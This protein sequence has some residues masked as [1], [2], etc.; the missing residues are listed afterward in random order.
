MPLQDLTPQLRTRLSR[1]E[2]I[3]GVFIF[4]AT[5][6]MA[7][8]LGFYLYR[9]ALT[10]GW[11]LLKAPYYT[12]LRSGSGLRAGD[13][14]MMMGFP[15]G[16]ITRVEAMPPGMEQDVVVQFVVLGDKSGYIWSDS[17]VKVKS[18]GLLGNRY[19][20]VV[21]GDASGKSGK[22]Y[23]TYRTKGGSTITEMFD[24]ESKTYKPWSPGQ[25]IELRAEEPPDLS[26]HLD[27]MVQQAKDAMPHILALTN[28][29]TRVMANTADATEKLNRVLDEAGPVVSNLGEI[30]SN[31]K[32]PNGSLGQW[33]LPTNL[34]A[35]VEQAVTS[36]NTVLATANNTLTNAN[37]QLT[38]VATSL[39]QALENL[40]GITGNL[41]KQVDGNTNMLGQVS[42]L[43]VDTDD[44]VQ[45]LKR[46][47]LLRSA[48]RK[49]AAPGNAAP[50]R[51]KDSRGGR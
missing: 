21:K 42:R 6:V 50:L 10:R 18:S 34:H 26:S 25:H 41:R 39:D 16:E 31:L 15:V 45:G 46:H 44:M 23:E 30:T 36:A 9:T 22:V 24:R 17:V 7:G 20:E 48:F 5:L 29:L 2:R 51:P 28:L 35:Q 11:F 40:A 13:K 4:V 37:A 43:I 1:V 12:Y 27:S 3:V 33:L 32:D 14:V 8:G 19:L 49:P 47:W 38:E